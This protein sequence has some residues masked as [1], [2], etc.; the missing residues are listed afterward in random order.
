MKPYARR[1]AVALLLSALAH[2]I[3]MEL[4]GFRLPH[5]ETLPPLTA[6]LEPLPAS[7]PVRPKPKRHAAR[8]PAPPSP[9]PL[10]VVSGQA[11]P[12]VIAPPASS[13]AAESSVAA[14]S[15]VEAASSVAAEPAPPQPAH[16]LPKHARLSFLV[17][18]GTGDFQIGAVHNELDIG[19]D[20]Y[21]LHSETHTVGLAKLFKDYRLV[22]TSRGKAD[23]LG[24]HPEVYAE[25]K[26]NGG[27][28]QTAEATFDRTAQTLRF[29]AGGE[30]PMP[31]DAQDILSIFYNLSQLPLDGDTVELHVS[32][33]RK[34]ETYVLDIGAE[35]DI[36]T[37][38]GTLRALH[39]RKRRAAGENGFEIWLGLEYRL[40]P[41]EYLLLDASGATVGRVLVS[42]IRVADEQKPPPNP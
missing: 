13:V 22:Q 19:D 33:G 21:V 31:A 2:G 28:V 8:K 16:P 14:A 34:L 37:P 11:E 5:D 17:Y 12:S 29:S 23:R 35:E 7:P 27:D 15:S 30:T 10:P 6:K 1:I 38:M 9:P 32:N 18:Q 41:V 3:L 40:F 42:D 20:G 39:L 26:N 24:L 4:P 36:A 25:E